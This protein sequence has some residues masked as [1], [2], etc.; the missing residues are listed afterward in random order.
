MSPASSF[1][2]SAYRPWDNMVEVKSAIDQVLDQAIRT[3]I[4]GKRLLRFRYQGKQRIAEPHDYGI[5][6]GIVRLFVYQIEGQ[7]TTRL[8][9]WRLVDVSEMRDY[10]VLERQFRGS[11]H[12]SHS[13][14]REWDEIFLRVM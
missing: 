8:P 14:H 10:E 11:R 9:G 4:L 3:A 6:K 5:H 12:D 7:S 13:N 2:E 1:A